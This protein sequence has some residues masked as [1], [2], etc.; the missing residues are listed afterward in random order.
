MVAIAWT[1]PY[2]GCFITIQLPFSVCLRGKLIQVKMSPYKL[3]DLD[4]FTI[5][6]R[7]VAIFLKVKNYL[8]INKSRFFLPNGFNMLV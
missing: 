4:H 7:K 1:D 2:K 3:W 5:E 6:L 8:L